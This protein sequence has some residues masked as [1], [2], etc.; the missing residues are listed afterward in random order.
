MKCLTCQSEALE[1]FPGRIADFVASRVGIEAETSW[2]HCTQCGLSWCLRRFT[3][4][5]MAAL[6]AGYR[7]DVY[8][9]ERETFEPGYLQIHEQITQ[10]RPY[11]A[12]IEAMIKEWINPSDAFDIGTLDG[13][14]RP[15]PNISYVGVEIGDEWP[16][17]TFDLVII[18]HVLEH[19]PDPAGLL[20]EAKTRLKPNGVLFFEVPVEEDGDIWHEHV[21][22]FTPQALRAVMPFNEVEIRAVVWGTATIL[23]GMARD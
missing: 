6:Y 13:I 16:D 15:F 4:D 23:V 19:V 21:Q 9:M 10:P 22:R 20:S 1:V 8:V 17:N 7:D 14:N 12:E 11:R 2:A 5:Q 18:Q 3:D